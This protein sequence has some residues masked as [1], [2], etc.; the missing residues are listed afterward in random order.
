[1]GKSTLRPS[2]AHG[3]FVTAHKTK[4]SPSIP[5]ALRRED[6][7]RTAEGAVPPPAALGSEGCLGRGPGDTHRLPVPHTAGPPPPRPPRSPPVPAATAA[8]GPRLGAAAPARA[9]SASRAGTHLG[10]STTCTG[11]LLGVSP[12]MAAPPRR[13]L[14]EAGGGSGGLAV[15]GRAGPGLPGGGAAG[16]AS[17]SPPLPPRRGSGPGPGAGPSPAV[18]PPGR[19]RRGSAPRSP[20]GGGAAQLLAQGGLQVAGKLLAACR[21]RSVTSFLSEF[22]WQQRTIKNS[23]RRGAGC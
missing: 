16:T 15:T 19:C 13:P 10:C 2:E 7:G 12:A 21:R 4:G 20:P 5:K 6:A 9:R 3:P 1:M 14:L 18:Q 11:R 8:A 22:S 23:P 17:S